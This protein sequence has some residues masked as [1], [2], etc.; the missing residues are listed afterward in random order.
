M[1]FEKRSFFEALFSSKWKPLKGE[2]G[3][4]P[5]WIS[6]IYVT[7][8]SSLFFIP[9]GVLISVYI[10]EYSKKKIKN[11]LKPLFDILSAIPS[12]VFGLWGFIVVVPAISFF[13]KILGFNTSGYSIF[14]ASIVLSL[15]VLPI[16]I[17]L[18][19]E[20]F[21]LVPF[22]LKEAVLSLGATKWEMVKNVLIPQCKKGIVAGI[23]LSLGRVVS[24]TMA[25]M[26]VVGNSIK[27][28]KT[29][30]DPAYPI[31]A[32]IANNFGEMMS[33]P[34]YREALLFS[35]LLLNL[36]VLIFHFFLRRVILRI[37][38]YG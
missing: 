5:F 15:M 34:S 25:V 29:P 23:F 4:L 18:L 14:S 27:I 37:K 6:T 3:F 28:P 17:S 35:A 7:L 1:F 12:V 24:E 8:F 36:I 31:P 21:E 32:L 20:I 16:L 10:S 2:F 38:L 11:L 22:E 13:G 19:I 26:M 33:I 30:F 9:L